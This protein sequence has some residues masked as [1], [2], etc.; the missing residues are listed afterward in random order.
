[1]EISEARARPAKDLDNYAKP[2][3]DAVTQSHLL[4]K[5]DNQI[6]ELIIRRTRDGNCAESSV[7]VVL[8]RIEGQHGG[9]PTHFRARCAEASH[10]VA[11]GYSGVGYYLAATLVSEVPYDLED[12]EWLEEISCLTSMLDGGEDNNVWIWFQEHLPEF[13]KLVP[14]DRKEQ[15]L[16]GVW[17]AY[18]K[19]RIG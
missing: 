12:D 14:N 5:D 6:D 4:W 9:V 11:N 3:I 16:S 19:E 18:E 15:F 8:R 7:R 1:M 10:G 17:K 2:I 13:M